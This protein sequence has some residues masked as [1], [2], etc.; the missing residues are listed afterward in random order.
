VRGAQN[1]RTES[2]L[3]VSDRIRLYLSGSPR[4]KQ[5]WEIYSAYIS[6]E[7][8]A[9]SAEWLDKPP[10]GLPAG[11]TDGL[12]AIESGAETWVIRIEKDVCR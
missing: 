2:G 7:L 8:L 12:T 10:A 4:L 1:L 9:S 5:A 11:K 3:E 6:S